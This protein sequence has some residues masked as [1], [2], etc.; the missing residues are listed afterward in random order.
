[1]WLR[2]GMLVGG[3]WS[4]VDPAPRERL[5]ALVESWERKRRQAE[6]GSRASE[7]NYEANGGEGLANGP[8]DIRIGVE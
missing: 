2:A 1:M 6:T 7:V 4:L 3:G 5:C 8:H